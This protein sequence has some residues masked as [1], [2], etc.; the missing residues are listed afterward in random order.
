[1]IHYVEVVTSLHKTMRALQHRH[2]FLPLVA[3]VTHQN[4]GAIWKQVRDELCIDFAQG[5]ALMPAPLE[6]GTPG[7]RALDSQ[8]AGKWLRSLLLL[9]D[10]N[11]DGRKVSSH[12]LISRMLSYLAK[13]GA[14]MADRLLLGCHTSPFTMGLTY[15]RDGMARPLQIWETCWK[16]YAMCVLSR[17]HT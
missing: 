9:D 7:R 15:S 2:Q 3:R 17:L 10:S 13:R 6:D 8:E 5:H 11:L 12:S 14:D 4:W 1:V 16:K